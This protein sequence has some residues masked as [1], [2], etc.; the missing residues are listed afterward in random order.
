MIQLFINNGVSKV[1]T[2]VLVTDTVI[3]LTAGTGSSFPIVTPTV[4]YFLGTLF[5]IS[6]GIEYAYEI[7]M[8]TARTGDTLTVVRAQEGTTAQAYTVGDSFALR[9]TRG[10]LENY[11]NTLVAKTQTVNG[12]PLSGNI[13]VT[14]SDVGAPAGSGTSTGTNTGD[15]VWGGIGGTLS[16]Q[17]DLQSA[18]NAK[19]NTSAAG[20]FGLTLLAELTVAAARTSLGLGTAALNNYGD[21]APIAHVGSGGAA[22]ALVISGVSDGFM[23]NADKAK[24]DALV[25][26]GSTLPPTA[27]HLGEFLNA[28]GTWHAV[29]QILSVVMTTNAGT[30]AT[31]DTG[32]Y[33]VTVTGALTAS[34]ALT[35]TQ[36]NAGNPY[37]VIFNN[38]TT[39]GYP[40]V[41]NGLATI[42]VGMSIYY[43][44]GSTFISVTTASIGGTAA[45][46]SF[47]L[48]SDSTSGLYETGSSGL[49]ISLATKDYFELDP[50]AFQVGYKP[51]APISLNSVAGSPFVSNGNGGN[52]SVLSPDGLYYYTSSGSSIT[53][54]SRNTLT[55]VLT[56][57]A[58]SPWTVSASVYSIA[59]SPDGKMLVA[60][61]QSANAFARFT[62]N[63]TTGVLTSAGSDISGGVSPTG[64]CFSGDNGSVYMVYGSS[65][66]GYTVNTSTGSAVALAG[67][68]FASGASQIKPISSPDG[69]NLYVLGAGT[70]IITEFTRNPSTGVISALGT[71]TVTP[72]TAG[73]VFSPDGNNLYVTDTSA[74]NITNISRD[75]TTGALTVGASVADGLSHSAINITADGTL[76]VTAGSSLST[77]M[78][79]F[80]RDIYTGALTAVSGSPFALAGGA[81]LV[82][83]SPDGTNIITAAGT[84]ANVYSYLTS[85]SPTYNLLTGSFDPIGGPNGIVYVNGS[86]VAQGDVVLNK[87]Y[88]D[89][90]Y[91]GIGGT[92]I[93][94]N[95]LATARNIYGNSFN[96][97]ADLTAVIAA[98]YGGTN[99][100]F[101]QFT[102]PTTAIKTFTLP[103]VSDTIACL[104]QVNTYTKTQ[105]GN[106][107]VLS[108]V[109]NAVA[110]DLSLGNNFSLAL[111]ATTSQVLSNPTN[112]VAGT[113]GQIAI[114]QNATPSTLTFDTSWI[115][116]DGTVL[117]VSTTAGAVNL[118]TFY[119]V[120]ATH[121]WFSISKH[122]VA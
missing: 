61:M 114:T 53:G 2:P 58:G 19:I 8:V 100:A 27:G 74:S 117:A 41:V 32:V 78:G 108:V 79:I 116:N 49:G 68:P 89:A 83:I 42:P 57:I 33:A 4:N 35:L 70:S 93:S 99:N 48:A 80:S 45:L 30:G 18:L 87:T 23:S 12:H 88:S 56:Q 106:V 104:G 120:D 84:S 6:S 121:I 105:I 76:V 39:G 101:T 112:A 54:F 11:Q 111:Q 107:T 25:P 115:S 69:N 66:L 59:L 47:P 92:A 102:G 38:Q 43:Y 1:S 13:T 37:M 75:P 77:G 22:H 103:N 82:N 119:V 46:P 55:G 90:R 71:A 26:G 28:D 5:K 81:Y 44:N 15:Q 31:D 36:A 94:A 85:T 122:G 65:V 64:I 3:N 91:L 98:T 62:R 7:V 113:S 50:T 109:T 9:I 17:T 97:S 52:Y 110:L 29:T 73:M 40:L 14:A 51:A 20:A 95:G 63:A 16:S 86:L 21:F 67:N 118:L 72:T 60:S 96:G 10:T 34:G 24:L